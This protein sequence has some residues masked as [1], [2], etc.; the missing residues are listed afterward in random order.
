LETCAVPSAGEEQVSLAQA[1]GMPPLQAIGWTRDPQWRQVLSTLLAHMAGLRD[2][3]EQAK[4]VIASLQERLESDPDAIEA[5]ADALLAE[6][7]ADVDAATAPFIMAALQVYWTSLA[8][9][10]DSAK[11]PVVS[12]F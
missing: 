5:Q 12:P 3:P 4:K 6:R 10:F 9:D 7:D 1:H 8:I 2:V 11:L